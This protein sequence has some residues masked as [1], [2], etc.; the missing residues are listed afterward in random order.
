LKAIINDWVALVTHLEELVSRNRSVAAEGATAK[1]LLGHLKSV[2]FIQT[3]HFMCDL[4]HVLKALS[5]K[6]QRDDLYLPDIPPLVSEC[7]DDIKNMAE[8]D[9]PGGYFSRL[10]LENDPEK[11][12]GKCFHGVKLTD[13]SLP[14]GASTLP[15]FERDRISIVDLSVE[16]LQKRFQSLLTSTVVEAASVL[17]LSTW[18]DTKDG[19]L[20][21]GDSDMRA[22][23]EHFFERLRRLE[24]FQPK[25]D[26]E[27]SDGDDGYPTKNVVVE[28][29][30]REWLRFKK[31]KCKGHLM[32]GGKTSTSSFLSCAQAILNFPAMFPTLGHIVKIIMV[33]PTSTACCERGFSALNR[34][35]TKR[36]AC[37]GGESL[38]DCLTASI[39]LP[40]L[41]DYNDE[42]AI[43]SW[44]SGAKRLWCGRQN[45]PKAKRP[46]KDATKPG[47]SDPVDM[48][49][50]SESD[51]LSDEN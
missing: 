17:D 23:G 45:A 51:R 7:I 41:D 16:Y 48:V 28:T 3:M 26:D 46:R 42:G 24:N 43:D 1:G 13:H 34:I 40:A 12:Q 5:L 31:R 30:G 14:R 21:Y 10:K 32:S 8:T 18:P 15:S 39:L 50:D 4:L 44:F 22:I 47:A 33:L 11:P 36:R 19:F 37:L 20:K 2:R 9:I 35:K 6:F 27:G 49:S 38:E 29:V 25:S